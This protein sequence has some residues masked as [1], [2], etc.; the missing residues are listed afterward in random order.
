[1]PSV[2]P[3][4]RGP[5]STLSCSTCRRASPRRCQQCAV[6]REDQREDELRD[7]D[8]VL[9]RTVRHVNARREAAAT[10]SCSRRPLRERSGTAHCGRA[11]PR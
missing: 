5:L 4:S 11:S 10:S 8:G 9:A 2:R 6:N 1:M 7:R 3:S